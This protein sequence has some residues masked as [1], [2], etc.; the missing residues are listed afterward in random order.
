MP[1][2]CD[3]L[4]GFDHRNGRAD[5]GRLVGCRA[6]NWQGK[7]EPEDHNSAGGQRQPGIDATMS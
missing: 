6:E 4:V 2:G 1:A 7:H 3:E 5:V